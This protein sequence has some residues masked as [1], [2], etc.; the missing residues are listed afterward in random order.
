V[1]DGCDSGHPDATH[2]CR[3]IPVLVD[4]LG[5]KGVTTIDSSILPAALGASGEQRV[6]HSAVIVPT[7]LASAVSP[8]ARSTIVL[9]L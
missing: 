6:E 2:D 4:A 7:R 8:P 3:D 9:Q 5:L 1:E